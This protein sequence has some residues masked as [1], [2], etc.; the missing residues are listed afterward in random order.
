MIQF[1]E[2]NIIIFPPPQLK[3]GLMKQFV[4]ALTNDGDYLKYLIFSFPALHLNLVVYLMG[5]RFCSSSIGLSWIY[6][7]TIEQSLIDEEPELTKNSWTTTKCSITTWSAFSKVL[8]WWL[9][10]WTIPAR[11]DDHRG[12]VSGQMGLRYVGRLMLE[13]RARLSTD[14]TLLLKL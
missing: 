9:V 2:N 7:S 12:T 13:L 5:R 4:N 1:I 8:V 3:L 14:W 11:I 10:R 6:T